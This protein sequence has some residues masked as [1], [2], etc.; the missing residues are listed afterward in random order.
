[1]LV[2]G[3]STRPFRTTLATTTTATTTKPPSICSTNL[4]PPTDGAVRCRQ[5]KFGKL[6][7]LSCPLGGAFTNGHTR[8]IYFCD[9]KRQA[10]RPEKIYTQCPNRVRIRPDRI[11]SGADQSSRAYCEPGTERQAGSRSCQPCAPGT[12]RPPR[13]KHAFCLQCPRGFYQAKRGALGCMRC[14]KKL[15]SA[16][17]LILGMKGA[18]HVI[19]CSSPRY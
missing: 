10:W 19:Y 6:C 3:Q 2:E 5:T 4:S 7:H 1:M 14:P 12:F 15:D 8:K 18:K 13:A 9:E 11:R 17:N 16:G